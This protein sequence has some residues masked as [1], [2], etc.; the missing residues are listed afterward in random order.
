MVV[1]FHG[2]CW[3]L[4]DVDTC[5][6]VC[7]FLALNA[8]AAVL[9]VGYRLAPEHPFPAAFDDALAAFRWASTKHSRLGVDPDRIAVAGDSA[10]GNLAAAVSLM[11][12]DDGPSP[13]MQV[14]LYPIVDAC[15]EWPSRQAFGEGFLLTKADLE[16]FE[17]QYL[18]GGSDRTDPRVS[19]LRADDLS[20]LPPTYIATAG[21]DPLRDEGAAYAA[22]LREAGAAVTWCHHP[23]L[24]HGFANLTAISHTARAA[25]LEL[26]G[27]IH[28]GLVDTP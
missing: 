19:L 26:A 24:I 9:S 10:G 22:A 25:M 11:A 6:S 12:R 4:G 8:G 21:F 16:W 15:E 13:A 2:G 20:G 23:G 1:Y 7:S 27:A 17:R 18:P 28:A 5:D 14:L 3:A